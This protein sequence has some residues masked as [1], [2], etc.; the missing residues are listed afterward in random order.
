MKRSSWISMT[1]PKRE[2]RKEPGWRKLAIALAL[3]PLILGAPGCQPESDPP[4]ILIIGI[5]GASPEVAFPMM[6]AGRLPHL[7]EIA[8]T[9]VH[10]PLRSVLPLYSPR[11]WNTIATGVKP[12]VH[13]IP[14]FV[15]PATGGGKALYLS[16]DRKVPA[17]WNILS[18]RGRSVG[19]VNWWTTFPPEKIEGVMVSDHFFPE[20]ID[21][22]K[23]TFAADRAS[24]GALIHPQSWTPRAEEQL[25]NPASL[26]E[27]ENFFDGAAELPRWVNRS[28]LSQQFVTDQEI[29]QV[30][31]ALDADHHLDVMMVFL[32][33]IDRV[34]HWLWGNLEA[35]DLYPPTLQPSPEERAGG[36]EALR[37]YYAYTD[38]LIGRLVAGYGPDDM[39]LV[40][41][42]HGFEAG[43]SLMLLTGAHDS[44]SALDGVLFA[45]GRGIPRGQ[46]AGP[47][48]VYEIA[49]SV[50]TFAGL[51]SALDMQAGP[52]KFLADLSRPDP[53][54]SYNAIAIERYAPS[55]SGHEE[56][57]IEHLRALGYLEEK[58]APAQDQE[59]APP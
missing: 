1:R 22:I 56:E 46:A 9:G 7:A 32:P 39:V 38:A 50:L 25:K 26:T 42:D 52:A 6:K 15:K 10:G 30:A 4:R 47:V 55:A 29:T 8:A 33:G 13:G 36:A 20:Q 44:P 48:N 31:L 17:L 41:S 37:A 28:L 23:K 14:A 43:V 5:D 59:Q 16:S 11:I 34:S 45:R 53:V 18:D 58:E 49:P 51:P 40:I 19:V 27:F 57:I 12:N 2:I 21:M 24:E 35:E 54:A 3:L